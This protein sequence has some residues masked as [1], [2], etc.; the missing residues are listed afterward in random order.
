M[1]ATGPSHQLAMELESLVVRGRMDRERG[2]RSVQSHGGER[3]MSREGQEQ[4]G[5]GKA[6]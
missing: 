4:D 1:I 5:E 6:E 3:V 2:R